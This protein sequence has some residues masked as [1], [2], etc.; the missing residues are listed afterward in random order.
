MGRFELALPAPAVEESSSSSKA[1]EV[2]RG[3]VGKLFDYGWLLRKH[4]E[5]F[6]FQFEGSSQ[7]F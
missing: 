2:L 1:G 6:F 3:K 4:V 5:M 7:R